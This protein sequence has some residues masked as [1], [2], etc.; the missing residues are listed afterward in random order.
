M[1]VRAI[2]IGVPLGAGIALFSCK[3]P[4][5]E[6][7]NLPVAGLGVVFGTAAGAGP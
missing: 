6:H 7:D 1:T 3:A 5:P 2:I 4:L